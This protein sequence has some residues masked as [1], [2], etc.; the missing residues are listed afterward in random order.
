MAMRAVASRALH[1]WSISGSAPGI[2]NIVFAE[3]ESL[4]LREVACVACL[5]VSKGGETM[6]RATSLTARST[7]VAS[8][9]L[10][11]AGMLARADCALRGMLHRQQRVHM[12]SLPHTPATALR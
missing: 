3:E 9:E 7:G 10:Q 8:T 6:L 5:R 1:G 4:A 12:P 2:A 11:L